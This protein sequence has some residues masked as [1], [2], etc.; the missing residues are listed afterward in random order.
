M[1]SNTEFGFPRSMTPK[2]RWENVVHSVTSTAIESVFQTPHGRRILGAIADSGD[3]GLSFNK[4]KEQ[5]ALAPS[6]LD[7]ALTELLQGVVI[8]NRLERRDGSRD[9]SYYRVTELGRVVY[10]EIE[11]MFD[12]TQ[13]RIVEH[14][15]VPEV[16]HLILTSFPSWKLREH[17]EAS[18]V[19]TYL[20][21]RSRATWKGFFSWKGHRKPG[22]EP[23]HAD[24]LYSPAYVLE[25]SPETAR[26]RHP[27]PVTSAL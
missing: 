14:S 15:R 16:S 13:Q 19:F 7:N 9:F 23:E 8:E 22:L 12:V 10:S 5:L 18:W 27:L 2:V 4:L 17:A 26:A 20:E 24:A 3:A 25:N 6:S 1:D 11:T 21:G